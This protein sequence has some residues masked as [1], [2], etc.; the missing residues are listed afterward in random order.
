MR[1]FSLLFVATHFFFYTGCGQSSSGVRGYIVESRFPVFDTI[2]GQWDVR[3][4]DSLYTRVYFFKDLVMIQPS[5]IYTN[6][7]TVNDV[8]VKRDPDELRYNSFIFSKPQLTGLFCD[9]NN[10]QTA[11]LVNKDSF[12]ANTWV[13]KDELKMLFEN[14]T[15]T[16]ISSELGPNDELVEEYSLIDK[17]DTTIKGS[18]K[19]RLT[20]LDKG[21]IYYQLSPFI[22]NE[23]K[24]KLVEYS[25][26]NNARSFGIGQL[27]MNKFEMPTRLNELKI[28]NEAELIRMFRFAAGK[29]K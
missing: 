23:K 19:M 7:K 10:L 25:I 5:F 6:V 8:V 15:H 24:M 13:F 21:V 2:N 11:R 29:L 28:S 22:E 12:L 1:L 4:Y 17:K 14:T 3:K 16:L 26:V 9:S 20:R 18:C 27:P